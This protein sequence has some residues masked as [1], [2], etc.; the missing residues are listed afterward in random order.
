V[1]PN[2][3]REYTPLFFPESP[4]ALPKPAKGGKH[5]HPRVQ[6]I[7][8]NTNHASSPS[9]EYPELPIPTNHSG[10]RSPGQYPERD[11]PPSR[12]LGHI[13]PRCVYVESSSDEDAAADVGGN[14]PGQYPERDSPPSR[15]LGHI[16][17]RCV[18]VESSSDEDAAADAGGNTAPTITRSVT[19]HRR[20]PWRCSCCLPCELPHHHNFGLGLGGNRVAS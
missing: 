4:P 18:Y 8:R 11:S 12:S 15:S 3:T 2:S 20:T 16:D 14:T 10:V 9:G 6:A 7:P 19:R 5:Q 1:T 17:P 13:D